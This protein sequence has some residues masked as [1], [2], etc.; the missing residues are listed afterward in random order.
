MTCSHCSAEIP[1][2][3]GF[4]PRCG[5]A[6]TA[7]PVAA[8]QLDFVGQALPLFGWGLLLLVASL[9]VIPAAWANAAMARWIFQNVRFSDGTTAT[10]QGTGGQIAGWIILNL[11][12]SFG[13]Q[14]V[15]R[16]ASQRFGFNGT[17][18]SL[19]VL[20]VLISGVVLKILQWWVSSIH[21][22]SG[23]ALR[24][25]AT[26]GGLVGWYLFLAISV[27]SVVGWAWV[28]CKMYSW[29]GRHSS[30]DGAQFDFRGKGHQF[31]WRV[32]VFALS[33]IVIIPIPWTALWLTRW[34]VQN[35]TL[36]RV[37][38]LPAEAVA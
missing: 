37:P 12:L 15:N 21:L 18:L 7:L 8:V 33:C 24:F 6:P 27:Y 26:Y 20:Y 3:A 19:I 11:L 5:N 22:S 28:A 14:F 32:L 17:I 31:L 23:E 35:L 4:C 10:F 2:G 9:L 25:T 36:T 34:L 1:E 38:V 16:W 30:G 29:L 13:F